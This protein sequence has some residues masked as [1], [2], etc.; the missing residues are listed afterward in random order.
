MEAGLWVRPC[1]WLGM[2][3]KMALVCTPQVQQVSI[4][5]IPNNVI[6]VT[7]HYQPVLCFLGGVWNTGMYHAW[8]A[9]AVGEG[10]DAVR[11][12]LQRGYPA[13]R[14]MAEGWRLMS[15]LIHEHMRR[16]AQPNHKPSQIFEMASLSRLDDSAR[17][18]SWHIYTP[19]EVDQ[20]FGQFP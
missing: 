13:P 20:A 15:K 11:S 2:T 9:T 14:S 6:M 7:T 8:R 16:R 1:Y 10:S 5:D 17:T 18:V 19:E 12:L 3:I 4:L